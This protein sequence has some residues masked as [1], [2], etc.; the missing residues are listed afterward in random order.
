MGHFE[1]QTICQ[2]A[3]VSGQQVSLLKRAYE[4]ARY[5]ACKSVTDIARQLNTEGYSTS[6]VDAQLRESTL[7]TELAKILSRAE[8]M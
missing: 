8:Q 6:G 5:G 7:S 1:P 3:I 4:L 2:L